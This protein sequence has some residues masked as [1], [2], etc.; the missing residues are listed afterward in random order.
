MTKFNGLVQATRAFV[1][2]NTPAI[3]TGIGVAGT[4]ATGILAARASLKV[5]KAI[6][7][8]EADNQEYMTKTQLKNFILERKLWSHYI[9]AMA[10]GSLTIVAIISAN[11]VGA[12]RAAALAA[13]YSVLEKGIDEY[14]DKVVEVIGAKKE[15][16]IQDQVAQDMVTNNPPTPS[17]IIVTGNGS[18]LCMESFTRRPF[19]SD[20]ETIRRAVNDVNERAIKHGFVSLSEF[21]DLLGLEQ[22]DQSDDIGWTSDRLL[23]VKYS[24]TLTPVENKPCMV[25]TYNVSPRHGYDR[26][27]Q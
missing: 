13:V 14:K 5:G 4:V 15:Q 11:R 17:N 7:Y 22:T 2:N 18:V 21:Y 19:I 23:E 27:D 20:M 1:T 3:L 8:E 24:A 9:P 6:A 12:R 26:F 25:I 10:T 16:A